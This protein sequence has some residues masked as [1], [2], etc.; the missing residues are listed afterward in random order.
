MSEEKR[1]LTPQQ[2]AEICFDEALCSLTMI[3]FGDYPALEAGTI[4]AQACRSARQGF[5]ITG[6]TKELLSGPQTDPFLIKAK[7]VLENFGEAFFTATT[8]KEENQSLT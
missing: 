2:E 3:N 8:D 7:A 4:Y 1:A 6:L 5:R